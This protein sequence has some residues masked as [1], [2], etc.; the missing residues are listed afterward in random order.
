MYVVVVG[1]GK[2]GYYLTRELL[3]AGHELV[4]LEK[5]PARRFANADE[6]LPAPGD[7]FTG[8][9]RFLAPGPGRRSTPQRLPR[10]LS[11]RRLRRACGSPARS[12]A[13]TSP[14]LST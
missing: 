7:Q 3:A 9:S 14:N 11:S 12:S 5:D 2:V 4:L 10:S 1:G 13:M 6:F 8:P